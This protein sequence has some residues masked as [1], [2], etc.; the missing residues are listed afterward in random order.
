[1]I[2]G[3]PANG[4][5]AVAVF[6]DIPADGRSSA[7]VFCEVST[8]GGG[9]YY[10]DVCRLLSIVVQQGLAHCRLLGRMVQQCL[11]K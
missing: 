8:D 4:W 11:V 2:S 6:G 1:M 7:A 10:R 9:G 3:V 5:R